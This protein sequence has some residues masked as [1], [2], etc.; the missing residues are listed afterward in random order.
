MTT[1]LVT[2][3]GAFPGAPDNPSADIV[4]ELERHWRGRFSRMG[5]RL[6]TAVLPVVHA[7]GPLIDALVAREKPDAIV[8]L[9]LAG[10]R[11]NVTVES[12]ARNIVTT[13]KPDARGAF[14]AR[15]AHGGKSAASLPA[16]WDTTQLV[17]RLRCAS[18]DAAPSNDA[19]DYVCNAV[20]WRSLEAGAAPAVFIHVPKKSRVPP[21]DMA[22]ALAGVLP[23]LT[24]RIARRRRPERETT[25]PR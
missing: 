21:A 12:R 11:R 3:F 17:A 25:D 10:R 9:G 22:R 4:A 16:G 23:S 6:A 19:G 13:L 8:H 24:L 14:A 7:I 20:L 5:V 18:V 2:A 15:R 1:L